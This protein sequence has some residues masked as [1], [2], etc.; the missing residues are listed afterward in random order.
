VA[1]HAAVYSTRSW[2]MTAPL[3]RMVNLVRRAIGR[4]P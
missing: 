2:R 4:L 1:R 3:R